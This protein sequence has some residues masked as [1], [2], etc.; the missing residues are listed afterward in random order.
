[1][2]GARRRLAV[3]LGAEAERSAGRGARVRSP[4][5]RT[6][7]RR[8]QRVRLAD[9]GLHR[10]GWPP[11]WGR[12]AKALE[13][14]VIEEEFRAAQGARGPNIGV[15][16]WALPTLI[17]LRHGRAAGAVDPADA[18]RRDQLVPAVQRARRGLRPRVAVDAGDAGRRRLGAQRPEGVD[19]D[20]AR[21]P[22]GASASRAP[23]PS[24]PKHDGISCFMVD[25]KTPGIDIRPLRELTG[26]G[27]VQR[28]VL[29]RRVRPRR[30]PRRR[31]ARRLA[32][33]RARRSR[34]S[35]STWAASNTI[36]G[37]VVGVLQGGRRT[38]GLADDRARARRGRRP[39]RSPA[40][41]SRCSASG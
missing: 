18:A 24:A 15:G 22:T 17:V 41:R 34:T 31:G 16:A 2:A 4:R 3:D 30:L 19:V 35:G 40:T 25:M 1:M 10:P 26:A 5:S 28:G 14:L 13:L 39:R 7:T 23:T 11:P 6:S 38:R 37:G 8:P 32:R 20:G 29:R 36:G 9:A 12:D 33:A 27:D 21:T